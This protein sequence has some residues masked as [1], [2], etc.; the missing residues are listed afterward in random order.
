M[1][2]S[3]PTVLLPQVQVPSTPST[4]FAFVVFVLY[5]V[6]EKNKNKQ[7][8]AVFGPFFK[9]YARLPLNESCVEAKKSLFGASKMIASKLN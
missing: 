7:K 5:L 4:F 9:T 1:D 8:E 3:A 2:L 6:C